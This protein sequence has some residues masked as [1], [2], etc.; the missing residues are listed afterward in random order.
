MKEQHSKAIRARL[1]N[2]LRNL[3]HNAT[4]N[5]PDISERIWQKYEDH[6]CFQAEYEIRCIEKDKL[7]LTDAEWAKAVKLGFSHNERYYWLVQ[8]I[9]EFGQLYTYG[10]GGRTLAPSQL[11]HDNGAGFRVFTDSDLGYMSRRQIVD[12]IQ[13]LEAFNTYVKNW[14]SKENLTALGQDYIDSSCPGC[15]NP[16]TEKIWQTPLELM[17]S[18]CAE[19]L[20][21]VEV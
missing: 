7:G 12:T 19:L 16:P 3:Y 4:P 2:A 21:P 14:N 20:S 15:K 5:H 8:R 10:R 9:T 6:F 1:N 17:C 13:I 18:S 11:V